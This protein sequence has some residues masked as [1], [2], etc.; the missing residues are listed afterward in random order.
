MYRDIV[1]R[2]TATDCWRPYEGI[3][4]DDTSEDG[5][6]DERRTSSRISSVSSTGSVAKDGPPRGAMS[7]RVRA[8]ARTVRV[9]VTDIVVILSGWWWSGSKSGVWGRIWGRDGIISYP[10]RSILSMS[11]GSESTA[12]FF[13]LCWPTLSKHGHGA[14]LPHSASR[15][16]PCLVP[17]WPG[18]ARHTK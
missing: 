15:P 11:F 7:E 1:T 14:S 13:T 10:N 17:S 8:R 16:S 2:V 4:F 3:D 5:D 6:A 12:F 9:C 18:D